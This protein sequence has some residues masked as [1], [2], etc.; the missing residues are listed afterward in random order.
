VSLVQLAIAAIAV[1]VALSAVMAAAW[2]VQQTTGKSGWVDVSWSFGV[3]GAAFV[4]A[5][6]PIESDWPHGLTDEHIGKMD[7]PPDLHSPFIRTNQERKSSALLVGVRISR[8]R[9]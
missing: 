5:L 9:V 1:S 2:C 3:G 6:W 8:N 4:A 7:E